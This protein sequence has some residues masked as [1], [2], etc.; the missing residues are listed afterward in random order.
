MCSIDLTKPLFRMKT[1]DELRQEKE[2]RIENEVSKISF[3][4][5]M[6]Q[7]HSIKM[8]EYMENNGPV[9]NNENQSYRIQFKC[10]ETF[11]KLQPWLVQVL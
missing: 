6:G 4:N 5:E 7:K 3:V 2:F 10:F 11:K 8:R 9:L 1:L